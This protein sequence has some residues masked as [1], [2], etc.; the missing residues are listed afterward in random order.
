MI[1]P[2]A[3]NGPPYWHRHILSEAEASSKPTSALILITLNINWIKTFLKMEKWPSGY[4][5]TFRQTYLLWN[6]RSG[7]PRGFESHLLQHI[8]RQYIF[9]RCVI[10]ITFACPMPLMIDCHELMPTRRSLRMPQLDSIANSQN[11]SL[12]SPLVP[13]DLIHTQINDLSHNS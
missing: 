12:A 3:T 4:G 2:F 11:S 6:F 10:L 9:D 7:K 1:W 8:Y 13:P 5:A